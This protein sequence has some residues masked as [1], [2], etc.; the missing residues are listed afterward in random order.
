MF[1]TKKSEQYALRAV[2]E[3]AKFSGKGPRKISQIAAAQSIPSRFLE[4]ILGQLKGSGILDSKRG[5]NGGYFL[6]RAPEKITVGEILRFLNGSGDLSHKISCMSK[7]QCP[8]N[9]N[10]AFL[11]MW[12]KVSGAIF[13]IYDQTTFAE[14]LANQKHP[15]SRMT[16]KSSVDKFREWTS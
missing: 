15:L 10:C 12:K 13:Q 16:G 2:L 4:V 1:R 7:K 14:L 3:L 9:C 6:L 11:P 8:F 5:Y